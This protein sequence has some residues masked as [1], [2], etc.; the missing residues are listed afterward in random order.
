[1]KDKWSGTVVLIGQ[2]AEEVIAGARM[3]LD[4]GLYRRPLGHDAHTYKLQFEGFS[5]TILRQ[6]PQHGA[7]LDDGLASL[8]ALVAIARSCETG[9]YMRLDATAGGV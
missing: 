3:M 7:T 4:D 6:A 9:G 5:D 1:M 8:Q 2:P